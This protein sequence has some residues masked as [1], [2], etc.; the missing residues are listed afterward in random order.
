MDD[1]PFFFLLYLYLNLEAYA[2]NKFYRFVV[3]SNS[4]LFSAKSG[5]VQ[6]HL[7]LKVKLRDLRQQSCLAQCSVSQKM[8]F[9][10]ITHSDRWCSLMPHTIDCSVKPPPVVPNRAFLRFRNHTFV[11]WPFLAAFVSLLLYP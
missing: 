3:L 9:Q 6:L 1:E 5:P 10:V 8:S 4:L 7:V 11:V 2:L